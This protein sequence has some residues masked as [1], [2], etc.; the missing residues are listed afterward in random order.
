MFDIQGMKKRRAGRALMQLPDIWSPNGGKKARGG[1]RKSEFCSE[2]IEGKLGRRAKKWLRLTRGNAALG[3]ELLRLLCL[4][5]T[6]NPHVVTR[7][8]K[9]SLRIQVTHEETRHS[10]R[11]LWDFLAVFSPSSWN[12]NHKLTPAQLTCWSHWH[13]SPTN[14]PF[15][16]RSFRVPFA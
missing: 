12:I 1:C 4:C 13:T 10:A 8:S 14:E 9:K 5:S 7:L 6:Q 16:W 3:E 2:D 11:V 15:S